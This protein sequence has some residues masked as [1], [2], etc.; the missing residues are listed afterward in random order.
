M[1]VHL[2]NTF[3][4]FRWQTNKAL[5][6]AYLLFSLLSSSL[7]TKMGIGM[8]RFSLAVRLPIKWVIKKTI[9]RQFCGGETLE[10]TA[11]VADKLGQYAVN[12]ILD[13]GVEGKDNEAAFDNAV[14]EFINA[15]TFAATQKNIPFISLKITGFARFALL[16]KMHSGRELTSA[17]RDEWNKVCIR[18]DR[19]CSCAAGNKVKVLIDA[20][21]TWIQDPC[22]E[23]TE[24]MMEKYNHGQAIVFNTFQLYCSGTLDFL[25]S[26]IEQSAKRGYILGAKLVRGAY[27]EKERQRAKMMGYPDPIQP[28]KSATDRD[29]DSAIKVCMNYL[30]KMEL[31]IGTHN[32]LSNY[33]A[34]GYMSRLHIPAADRRVSFSQLLGMGDHISFNL[35]NSG[36]NV[37]KYVPYGPVSDVVP[38]LMRRAQENTSVAGQTNRELTLIR[39]ELNRRRKSINSNTH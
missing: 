36:Y 8:V 7:F 32:E 9:F 12:T 20:E 37:S 19:I 21:E 35:A 3:I 14:P 16:E 22:N 30:D 33:L 29:F 4:A 23:I 11:A 13:Y 10:E 1:S 27:M 24:A 17:E 5:K 38:Y 39:T 2:D 26:C 18:I 25:V 6:R 31:F 34:L 28:D 15:I